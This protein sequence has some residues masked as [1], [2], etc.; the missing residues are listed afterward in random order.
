VCMCL[1]EAVAALLEVPGINIKATA[2][3]DMTALHFAAQNGHTDIAR[4]LITAGQPVN[5]KTRKHV[6]ALHLACQKGTAG[7]SR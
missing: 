6:T 5:S 3:D 2:V 4:M 7:C 1:Q